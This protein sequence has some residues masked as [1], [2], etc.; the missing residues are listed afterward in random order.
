M[1]SVLEQLGIQGGALVVNIV[2]FLLLIYLM[3]RFAFKPVGDF[4]QQRADRIEDDLRQARQLREVAERRHRDLN[5]ELQ[6]IRDQFR[7]EIARNSREAKQAIAQLHAE[8]RAQRQQ[9]QLDAEAQLQHA[10]KAMLAELSEQVTDLATEIAARAL[11]DSLNQERQ[12]ALVE[13]FM[14]DV[15]RL[16]LRGSHDETTDWGAN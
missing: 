12:A 2:G 14:A 6:E 5:D 8:N 1:A 3:R 4:M 16:S 13:K 11:R 9:M 15:E 10:R 7:A